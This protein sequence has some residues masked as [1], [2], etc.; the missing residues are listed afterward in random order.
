MTVGCDQAFAQGTFLHEAFR[1]VQLPCTGIMTFHIQPDAMGIMFGEG[2]ANAGTQ[3]GPPGTAALAIHHDAPE[4]DAAVRRLQ[5][6]QHEKADFRAICACPHDPMG[7]VR[8]A[9]RF[10]ML[11]PAPL[12]NVL[13]VLPVRFKGLHK[14]E[15]VGCGGM[16]GNHQQARTPKQH[17]FDPP[18]A[19]MMPEKKPLRRLHQ[20]IAMIY[21][22][23][24]C[25]MH[26]SAMQPK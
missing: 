13:P 3:R 15:I 17:G 1:L 24:P 11:R 23:R 26:F 4:F 22:A 25:L 6:P 21:A 12:G 16:H 8:V 5:A 9:Q 2:H 19:L 10:Q 7:A 14:I 18:Q 20:R